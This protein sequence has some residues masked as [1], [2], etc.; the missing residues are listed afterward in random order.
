MIDEFTLKECKRDKEILE[1]KIKNIE[2]AIRQSEK[3]IRES[4]MED[5]AL[6]FLKRKIA[7]SQ[8]DLEILY[9]IKINN[10]DLPT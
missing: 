1:L 10:S 5:Q 4:T 6:S 9:L 8:Q 7:K 2:H 3:I